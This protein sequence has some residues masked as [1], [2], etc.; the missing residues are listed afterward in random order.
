MKNVWEALCFVFLFTYLIGRTCA[1]TLYVAFINDE[2][3][4]PKLVLFSVPTESYGVEV[5]YE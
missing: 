5:N 3:K 4:K 2:S 1:V